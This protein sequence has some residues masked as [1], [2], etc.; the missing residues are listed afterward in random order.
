[1]IFTFLLAACV[2]S[3]GSQRT[4]DWKQTDGTGY[5][6]ASR[7]DGI[8]PLIARAEAD[9]SVSPAFPEY[10]LR[11]L[12]LAVMAR[13]FDGRTLLSFRIGG[14]SDVEAVYIFNAQGEITE[15]YLHSYWGP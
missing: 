15:R 6:R 1:M 3:G 2:S 4:W 14:V 10:P 12:Y 8:A 13:H 11:P 5:T 9:F 7:L